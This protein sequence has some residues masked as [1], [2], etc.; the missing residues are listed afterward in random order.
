[1]EKQWGY[2]EVDQIKNYQEV[3]FKLWQVAKVVEPTLL[4]N[5]CMYK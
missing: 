4:L 5:K 2:A 1:M 3:L